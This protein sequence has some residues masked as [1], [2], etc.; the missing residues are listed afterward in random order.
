V[1]ELEHLQ[2][3]G[4]EQDPGGDRSPFH[5]DAFTRSDQWSIISISHAR[6]WPSFEEKEIR[7]RL[8]FGQRRNRKELGKMGR[9]VQVEIPEQ[10]LQELDWGEEQVVQEIFQLG[11]Y[12]LKV[13]R[14]LELYR[15]GAGSLGYVAERLGISKRDLVREARVR[16]IEPAYDEQILA[17]ELGE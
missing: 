3:A 13:R 6:S 16:G 4:G 15:S 8:A 10:W 5:A 7:H 1:P 17:E 11:V 12:Q 14:A 9:M 2:Q